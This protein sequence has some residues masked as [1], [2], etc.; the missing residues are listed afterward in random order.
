MEPKC[1]DKIGWLSKTA[2]NEAIT[3]KTILIMLRVRRQKKACNYAMDGPQ[4]C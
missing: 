2:S 1:P 3:D 4:L